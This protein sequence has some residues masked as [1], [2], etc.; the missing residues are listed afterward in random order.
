MSTPPTSSGTQQN[1]S[2][3][4]T[5]GHTS[6]H[7]S[8]HSS[9]RT[10]GHEADDEK[11]HSGGTA[12]AGHTGTRETFDV[13]SSDVGSA[14]GGAASTGALPVPP[15][16]APA[17]PWP[18][19]PPDARAHMAGSIAPPPP[20]NRDWPPGGAPWP[21]GPRQQMAPTAPPGA[22][23]ALHGP[24]HRPFLGA[25]PEYPPEIVLEAPVMPPDVC[26]WYLVKTGLEPAEAAIGAA[27]YMPLV[28]P[29]VEHANVDY[30]FVPTKDPD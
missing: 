12:S 18:M 24:G 22:T 17:P 20:P 9:G 10:S 29:R 19:D 3:S 11:P 5:S 30:V 26:P 13:H 15:P 27:R 25:W 1:R 2:G 4:S 23:I 7:S 6:G 28:P 8:G 16:M 14:P 21:E